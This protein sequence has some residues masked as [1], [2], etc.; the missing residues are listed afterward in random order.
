MIYIVIAT[1][2]E[3]RVRLQKCIDAIRES[4]IPHS[5]VIYENNDGG[6]V[7]ATK[8]AIEGIHGE[9]FLLNDDMVIEP[10]CLEK[11]KI[12]YDK[13]FPNKDGICQPFEDMHKGELAVAPYGHTD[14]IRPF[15]EHYIHNFWDNE[16]TTVMKVRGKYLY[17][18]EARM[19]HEHVLKN[20]NLQDETYAKNQTK[21]EHDRQIFRERLAKKFGIVD[22]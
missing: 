12:A 2:K 9:M 21:Y 3:R 1:T 17:V 15:L 7:L 22:K 16:L 5:I 19:N 18:P 14:T 10:D 6:C 13:A 4:T 20:P 11:L 8:K